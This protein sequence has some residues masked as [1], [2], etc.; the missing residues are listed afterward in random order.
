M[1]SLA[2][3][4]YNKLF[5]I[6]ANPRRYKHDIV[7]TIYRQKTLSIRTAVRCDHEILMQKG[8]CGTLILCIFFLCITASKSTVSFFF[9]QNRDCVIIHIHINIY[10][11]QNYRVLLGARMCFIF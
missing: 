4:T 10:F 5:K 6:V 3:K 11:R 9:F 7:R 1:R 8:L 2:T